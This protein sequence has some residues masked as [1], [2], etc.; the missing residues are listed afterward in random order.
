MSTASKYSLGAL[1][2][3]SLA[4][5][6]AFAA[7]PPKQHTE[8]PEGTYLQGGGSTLAGVEMYQSTDPDAPPMTKAEFDR[9]FAGR[10]AT[11]GL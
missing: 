1:A 7:E 5:S 9:D 11:R 6:M 3:L 4:M 10:T 8:T 2:S